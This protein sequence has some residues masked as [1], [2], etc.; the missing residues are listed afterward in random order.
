MVYR[1]STIR[2]RHCHRCNCRSSQRS[3][4][5]S[6]STFRSWITSNSQ[7]EKKHAD[8]S[9][10]SRKSCV[11]KSFLDISTNTR[12][13]WNRTI[14]GADLSLHM[15]K[16]LCKLFHRSRRRCTDDRFPVIDTI[17]SRTVFQCFSP[18]MKTHRS[19]YFRS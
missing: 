8:L 16:D 18:G 13:A 9:R 1:H 12:R 5:L 2:M 7:V 14:S 10:S 6:I 3:S 4:I 19:S 11:R 17:Y 15:N